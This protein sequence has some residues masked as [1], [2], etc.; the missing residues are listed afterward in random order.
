MRLP[1]SAPA[2]RLIK[3]LENIGYTVVR[4]KGSHIRMRHAGPPE[5]SITI[6]L[7]DALKIGMLHAILTQVAQARALRVE[8]LAKSL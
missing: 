1:R 3:C 4:Q 6:P 5:H 7:H 2:D 8:D